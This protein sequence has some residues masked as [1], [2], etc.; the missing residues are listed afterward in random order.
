MAAVDACSLA[1][2]GIEQRGAQGDKR[3]VGEIGLQV[4]VGGGDHFGQREFVESKGVKDGMKAGSDERS[5]QSL[6]GSVGDEE[7]DCAVGTPENIHVVAANG[8]ARLKSHRPVQRDRRIGGGERAPLN[9]LRQLHLMVERGARFGRKTG[10]P[11]CIGV[12]ILLDR[13][14]DQHQPFQAPQ[15]RGKDHVDRIDRTRVPVERA[16]D[17]GKEGRIRRHREFHL[18]ILH[19]GEVVG[20]DRLMSRQNPRST[21]LE[22]CGSRLCPAELVPGGE[23]AWISRSPLVP[24]LLMCSA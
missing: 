3:A 18:K 6:A 12:A 22:M 14:A 13:Q 17:G 20:D 8:Q 2:G 9:L 1:G 21:F 15:R 16:G 23:R 24:P 10:R 11:G 7:D 19:A 4:T 5:L